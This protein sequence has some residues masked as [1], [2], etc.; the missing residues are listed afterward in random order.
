M[1]LLHQWEGRLHQL[2]PEPAL[3]GLSP[4]QTW[5][6]L[7]HTH[8]RCLGPS[9]H[10]R[11]HQL[12]SEGLPPRGA[13][14]STW[15][16]TCPLAPIS[17]HLPPAVP[18]L[19][20]AATEAQSMDIDSIKP[21]SWTDREA[22]STRTRVAG[23]LPE[24]PVGPL[25]RPRGEVGAPSGGTGSP[26]GRLGGWRPTST[27]T[28]LKEPPRGRGGVLGSR[29]APRLVLP[30]P[31]RM[32]VLQQALSPSQSLFAFA[33]S[34][35]QRLCSCLVSVPRML[36]AESGKEEVKYLPAWGSWRGAGCSRCLGASGRVRGPCLQCLRGRRAG[37]AR[38]DHCGRMSLAACRQVVHHRGP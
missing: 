30:W 19:R 32:C 29:G 35:H 34:F 31:W 28:K 15:A 16:A 7:C 26:W 12:P 10:P 14:A 23:P 24:G 5:G 38:A 13:A 21:P 20:P 36:P 6:P 25:P 33:P 3:L 37:L 27:S 17:P 8:T 2:T 18:H 11:L 9:A 22:L 4:P 1:H